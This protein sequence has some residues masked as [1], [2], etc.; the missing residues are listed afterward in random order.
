MERDSGVILKGTTMFLSRIFMMVLPAAH[1]YSPVSPVP[2]LK[3]RVIAASGDRITSL[4][5]DTMVKKRDSWNTT[6]GK[7][8]HAGLSVFCQS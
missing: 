4:S 7:L 5:M 2:G 3:K 8:F 1:R 6:K